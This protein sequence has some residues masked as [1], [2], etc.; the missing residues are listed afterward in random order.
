MKRE[1][2]LGV[3]F[4]LFYALQ[5]G[6]DAYAEIRCL[7]SNGRSC[8]AAEMQDGFRYKHVL[9]MSTGYTKAEEALFWSDYEHVVSLT[10]QM[11]AGVYSRDYREDLV[12]FGWYLPGG[13]LESGKARFSGAVVP[14][15]IRDHALTLDND[16]VIRTTY[17]FEE[18]WMPGAQVWSTLILFNYNERT[19]PNAAPPMYLNEPFGIARVSRSRMDTAYATVHEMAH[20]GLNFLDE[21]IEDGF[22]NVSIHLLNA[23]AGLALSDGSWHG[24]WEG[25]AHR[26]QLYPISIADILAF[27]GNENT[28]TVSNPALVGPV[29]PFPCRGGMFF[30]RGVYRAQGPNIMASHEQND[31][32]DEHCLS[33]GYDEAHSEAQRRVIDYVFNHEVTPPR[34]GNRIRAQGPAGPFSNV[35]L[36][37]RKVRLMLFDADKNHHAYPTRY[38]KVE[39]AYRP[40]KTCLK[41]GFIPYPCRSKEFKYVMKIFEPHRRTLDL[42]SSTLMGIGKSLQGLICALGVKQIQNGPNRIDL[43]TLELDEMATTFLP[44][45]EFPLP[46]E[47]VEMPVPQAFQTYYWR[48]KTCNSPE[49]EPFDRSGNPVD[50]EYTRDNWSNWTAWSELKR[51]I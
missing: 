9:V 32:V 10:E 4:A 43:C 3:V 17:A 15:P 11:R 31:D 46:Y 35:M 19:T 49:C 34:P 25:M 16:E 36:T 41:W 29:D 1:K 18:K 5:W 20:A 21:Y 39:I 45:V 13:S 33:N 14:H 6:G 44:S 23:L 28:A 50:T 51:V 27:N 42:S 38:Y 30:G 47:N 26:L 8:S 7:K 24:F 48:F 22:E 2:T 40:R 37:G 12:Y